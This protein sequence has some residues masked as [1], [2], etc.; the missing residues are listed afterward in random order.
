MWFLTRKFAN[1]RGYAALRR[2]PQDPVLREAF[3][4]VEQT[5]P[6]MTTSHQYV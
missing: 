6:M 2:S 3:R 1:P 4:V 5:G